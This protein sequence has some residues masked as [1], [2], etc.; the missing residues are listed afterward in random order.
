MGC[1]S[2]ECLREKS[3]ITNTNKNP[4]VISKVPEGQQN[5]NNA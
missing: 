1:C 5:S 2:D 3:V 4:Q